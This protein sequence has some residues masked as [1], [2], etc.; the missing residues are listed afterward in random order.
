M[1]KILHCIVLLYQY[2]KNNDETIIEKLESEIKAGETQ[3][4]FRLKKD[5]FRLVNCLIT[6]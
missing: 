5:D 2:S 3:G 6:C 1:N 4:N